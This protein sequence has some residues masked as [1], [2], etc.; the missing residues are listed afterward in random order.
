MVENN[1]NNIPPADNNGGGSNENKKLDTRLGKIKLA[2]DGAKSEGAQVELA[3]YGYPLA[4]V[5]IGLDMY[6]DTFTKHE[7]QKK[8]YGEQFGATDK[9]T[10]ARRTANLRYMKYLK[11]A[12][13]VFRDNR[14]EREAL[15][16]DGDR[17]NSFAGWVEQSTVFYKNALDSQTIKDAMAKKGIT[18]ALLEAG[19]A[20][21][22]AAEVASANQNKEMSEAVKATEDRDLALDK[23]EKWFADFRDISIA[24]LDENPELIRQMG[25]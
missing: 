22:K 10:T 15:M 17:K 7:K 19:L 23:L 2:L 21:V 3:K 16:L 5:K 1:E 18:T 13:A 6:E 12:R 20:E 4:E 11:I 9:L 24:V 14:N 25:L 8:E